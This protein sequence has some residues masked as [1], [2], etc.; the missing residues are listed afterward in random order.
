[1]DIYQLFSSIGDKIGRIFGFK[2]VLEN[3]VVMKVASILIALSLVISSMVL[4][5]LAISHYREDR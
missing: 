3:I 2:P 1:L 4:L 5:V